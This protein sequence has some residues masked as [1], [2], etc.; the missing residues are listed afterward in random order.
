MPQQPFRQL[1]HAG[2]HLSGEAHE[3]DGCHGLAGLIVDG[4]GDTE[5][6]APAANVRRDPGP[7]DLRVLLEELVN[8][9][10]FLC[11]ATAQIRLTLAV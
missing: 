5:S 11:A 4:R 10:G 6:R 3:R 1:L 2:L 7:F 8:Q 9:I